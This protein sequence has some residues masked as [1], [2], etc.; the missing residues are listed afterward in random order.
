MTKIAF[1]FPGQGSQ[2]V[3]MGK[4]LAQ[5]ETGEKLFFQADEI[6]GFP[7][8]TLCFQGPEEEL[9]QTF[10][11]QPSILTVS[12]IAFELL[13]AK[14]IRPALAAGHSLGEYSAL[15]AAGALSFVDAVRLVR[16][17][18]RLMAEATKTVGG[19]MAAIVGLT[20]QQVVDLCAEA[21]AAGLVQAVNFNS[22]A[23][24]AI[25]GTKEGVAKAI[26]L[27]LAK[28]AKRA[29]PL[30]VSAPFHSSLMDPVA[31]KFRSELETAKIADAAIPVV[32]N[33]D[34]RPETKAG[35]IR[36]NLVK[37]INGPVRWTETIQ[38]MLAQGITTF[39]EVGPGKVLTG[40]LRQINK[41]AQCFP[42]ESPASIEELA[43]KLL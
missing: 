21:S 12:L 30:P 8:S 11:T 37:Q 39:I 7:L 3:G 15:A 6:L 2:Y 38:F 20:L 33:I 27:A 42:V 43:A 29:L 17:R 23:Q 26:E 24:T 34:A 18:G 1:L 9:K 13:K 31:E 10:N 19:G 14:G 16:I 25:S 28:G 32:A 4:D 40:L 41:E 5:T 36:R 22:P 35:E